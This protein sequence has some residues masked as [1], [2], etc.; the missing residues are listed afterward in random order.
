[1]RLHIL[2]HFGQFASC[3]LVS[4]VCDIINAFQHGDY[5]LFENIA[6]KNEVIIIIINIY[7]LS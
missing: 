3:Q 5:S 7:L 4:G 2:S 1:M 6:T